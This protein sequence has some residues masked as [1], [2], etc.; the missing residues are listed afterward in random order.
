MSRRIAGFLSDL[1]RYGVRKFAGI[2]PGFGPDRVVIELEPAGPALPPGVTRHPGRPVP[3]A[4]AVP[5]VATGDTKDSARPARDALDVA[6]EERGPITQDDAVRL[7]LSDG[8][9]N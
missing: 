7:G 6:L 5:M 2:A 3:P 8:E 9:S 1:Q 4:E